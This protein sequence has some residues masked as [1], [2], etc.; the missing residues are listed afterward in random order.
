MISEKLPDNIIP[1]DIGV[2]YPLVEGEEPREFRGYELYSNSLLGTDIAYIN[3]INKP[4]FEEGWGYYV[5]ARGYDNSDGLLFQDYLYGLYKIA[6][7]TLYYIE[8]AEGVT[9]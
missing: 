1:V 7:F 5:I 6:G 2:W 8:T 3:L 4:S 9:E